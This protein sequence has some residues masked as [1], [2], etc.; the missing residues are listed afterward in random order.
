MK[1][2]FAI[3]VLILIAGFSFSKWENITQLKAA[4]LDIVNTVKSE[5]PDLQAFGELLQSE[6]VNSKTFNVLERKALNKILEEQKLET[7]GITESQA[8]RVGK[9]LNA[10]KIIMGTLSRMDKTYILVI[11]GIDVSTG[12]VEISESASGASLPELLKQV[13]KMAQ[14]LI[15][16][17]LDEKISSPAS[18]I[19]KIIISGPVPTNGLILYYPLDKN[20]GDLSGNNNHGVPNNVF[21]ANDRFGRQKSAFL[22]KPD[23][24]YI[25]SQVKFS[26]PFPLTLSIWFNTDST[27]GGRMLGFGDTQAD[28]SRYKDRH[29]Y[30]DNSGRVYFGILTNIDCPVIIRTPL[31]YNDGTWHYA[32]AVFSKA[33]MCLYIDGNPAVSNTIVTNALSYE[34]WWRVGYDTLNRWPAEPSYYS[35]FGMLDDVRIYGRALTAEEISILYHE[36]GWTGDQ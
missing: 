15:G 11:K 36:N 4:V 33:G 3:M 32:A 35:F 25:Y 23:I 6:L 26:N 12:V 34:G 10:D 21:A 7:A 5:K 2:W 14:N 28:M 29:L 20:A 24:N 27:T 16:K 17:A 9:L 1:K 8:S 18:S 19:T 13:P 22:M 31:T 30:M